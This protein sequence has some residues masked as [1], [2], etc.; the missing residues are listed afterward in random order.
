MHLICT[1]NFL[2]SLHFQGTYRSFL[3]TLPSETLQFNAVLEFFRYIG[4]AEAFVIVS[5]DTTHGL[6]LEFFSAIK[7]V[8]VTIFKI[9]ILRNPQPSV[10]K[11]LMQI[12]ASLASSV[13][14]H[15]D[16][17]LAKHILWSAKDFRVFGEGFF[18]VVSENIVQNTEHLYMLPSGIHAIRAEDLQYA[19]RF[20]TD[21]LYNAYEVLQ[22]ALNSSSDAE[23]RNFVRKP[24]TAKCSDVEEWKHGKELY[25]SVSAFVITCKH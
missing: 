13:F 6:A 18:W 22:K 7:F 10:S 14:L 25:R 4:N 2:F 17:D 5:D 3:R 1:D 21:R 12:K 15:C 16:V 24:S 19:D 9:D 11:Y 8:T 20:F 23:L